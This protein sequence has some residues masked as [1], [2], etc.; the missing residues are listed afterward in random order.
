MPYEF[1]LIEITGI[2]TLASMN[3]KQTWQNYRD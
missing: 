2:E 3:P 1:F